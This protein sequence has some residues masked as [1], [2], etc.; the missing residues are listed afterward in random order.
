MSYDPEESRSAA[1]A[2]APARE[3]DSAAGEFRSALRVEPG[4]EMI[5]VEEAVEI[6]RSGGMLIVVDDE[7]RENEGDFVCAAQFAT[8]DKIN[9]MLKHAR[10]LLC[11]PA[12]AA[13]LAEL[14]LERMAPANTAKHG[15]NFTI[16]VD[17]C[18]TTT[19]V[20]AA[21]RSVTI[22]S[23][24]N[25]ATRAEDLLRPGHVMP[26][27]ALDGGTLVRAGHTEA[28][29]D[30]ARLAGLE[31][32]AA[33]CEILNEDGSMAR[34][35]DLLAISRRFQIPI[36][37]IRDLIEYRMRREKLVRRVLTTRLPN[38]FGEWTLHLYENMLSGEET[39]ALVMGEPEKQESALIRVHSKC[40]TGESFHSLRCECGPQL[41][42][43]MRLIAAEGHGALIYMDQEGRGIGL[44][45]KLRAYILQDQ[46]LDTV[47]ANEELGFEADLREYG[48]GAQILADLGLRRIR[49]L[50][51]NPR[52]IVGIQGFGLEVV[53]R[54]P[55]EVGRNP[56]N[57]RYLDAKAA[58]LG[59]IFLR[60]APDC[61]TPAPAAAAAPSTNQEVTRRA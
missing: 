15:T 23:I 5:G 59:H 1:A 43:A 10:G 56:N 26:L 25:P 27:V 19:G 3:S 13:R 20:S 2:P 49:I 39:L 37:T 50:T 51:N 11:A 44:R 38:E 53:G 32:A 57:A 18:S 22:R 6:I 33:L 36:L 41:D 54:A 8:P 9:F 14:R 52:K 47:E 12:S 35:P 17:H 7:N 21:E 30:L 60:I 61:E 29:V 42:A 58:K 16:T 4:H 24:A 55:L 34:M 28:S 45:N 40:L 31:P 48:I 46:G